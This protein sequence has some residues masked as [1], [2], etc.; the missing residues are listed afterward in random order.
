MTDWRGTATGS[1]EHMA[2]AAIADGQADRMMHKGGAIA[3]RGS[4]QVSHAAR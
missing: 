1:G 4:R 2:V 3:R